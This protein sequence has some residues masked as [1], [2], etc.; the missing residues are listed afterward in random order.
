MPYLEVGIFLV[1]QLKRNGVAPMISSRRQKSGSW[2]GF[3][4]GE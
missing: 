3:N 4:E 2:Q 1:M